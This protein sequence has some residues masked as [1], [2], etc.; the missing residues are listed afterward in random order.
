M[1]D[2]IE[3]EQVESTELDSSLTTKF[4]LLL[5]IKKFAAFAASQA[6]YSR[7]EESILKAL[8]E[9]TYKLKQESYA[10]IEE[11]L[12]VLFLALEKSKLKKQKAQDFVNKKLAD[13]LIILKELVNKITPEGSRELLIKAG[14]LNKK[15]KLKKSLREKQ[16]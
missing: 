6:I 9:D 4:N 15:G 13:E 14:I 5:E 10:K 16:V 11:M 2:K 3:K 8:S 7:R 12:N 1:S